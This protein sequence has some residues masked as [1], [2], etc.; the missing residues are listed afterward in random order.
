[1]QTKI[2]LTNSI[3]GNTLQRSDLCKV[4]FYQM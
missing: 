3:E 1:M 4:F 2:E